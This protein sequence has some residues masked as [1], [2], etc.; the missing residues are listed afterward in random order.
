[1]QE[2]MQV[3]GL[4]ASTADYKRC[5]ETGKGRDGRNGLCQHPAA[6]CGDYR[7]CLISFHVV[8]VT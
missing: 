3:L 8:Y 1:M 7:L 5:P 2:H 4:E 6:T